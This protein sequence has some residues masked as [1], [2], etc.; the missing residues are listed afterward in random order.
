[1]SMRV[2]TALIGTA[3]CTA[4][5]AQSGAALAGR[6]SDGFGP[7]RPFA[8]TTEL[9]LRQDST[10]EISMPDPVFTYRA[11]R[12]TSVGRWTMVGDTVELDPELVPLKTTAQAYVIDTTPSD[13][14]WIELRYIVRE[15]SLDRVLVTERPFGFEMVSIYFNG[16][17]DRINVR[18]EP[19]RRACLFTPRIKDQLMIGADG[20]IRVPRRRSLER[21][22]FFTYGM[23]GIQWCDVPDGAKMIRLEVVQEVDVDRAPRQRRVVIEGDRAYF[24]MRNGAIDTKLD[25][26]L[27]H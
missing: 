11:Q 6:Y 22:G 2:T 20:T 12:F 14:I 1:M 5:S 8:S 13:S 3:W 24:H 27:R 17:H 21:L 16:R 15:V 10:F 19:Q 4:V 26:L 7:G 18:H 25:C 23:D 9:E